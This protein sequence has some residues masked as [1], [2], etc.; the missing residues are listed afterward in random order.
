MHG[1]RS[2]RTVRGERDPDLDRATGRPDDPTH[3][4][5]RAP[6]DPGGPVN[7]ADPV[8]LG[9]LETR[10]GPVRD[11]IPPTGGVERLGAAQAQRH[12]GAGRRNPALGLATRGPGSAPQ[13]ARRGPELLAHDLVELP[14]AREP[15]GERDV[16]HA[17]GGLVEQH[18][19]EL[20]PSG[21]R[22]LDRCR[23][24]LLDQDTVQVAF[25][26]VDGVGE[27]PDP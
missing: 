11:V 13:G 2:G 10:N 18:A 26:H 1:N 9:E 7:P 27:A 22:E 17:E 20:G 12:G 3:R 8:A 16:R 24:D 6:T 21:P 19:R 23:T 4:P 25:A 14:D 15:G 5:V